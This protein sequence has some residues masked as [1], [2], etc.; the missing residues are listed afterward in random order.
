MKPALLLKLLASA[1]LAVCSC[2]DDICSEHSFNIDTTSNPDWM[3]SLPDDTALTALSIPGTHDTMTYDVIDTIYQCNNQDLEMQLEAGVRYFDIRG[4]L[5]SNSIQIYHSIVYTGY[6]L[7]YVLLTFFSFLEHHPGE[8][9]IMRLKNEASPI[10]STISFEEGWK[11]YLY[12]NTATAS[13]AAKYLYM[14]SDSVFSPIPDLGQLR[15]KIL[16]LQNFES[17]PANKYGIGWETGAM[18]LEDFWQMSNLASLDKKFTAITDNLEYAA[19]NASDGLLYLTHL[20]ASVGVL[21]I[22]AAAGLESWNVTGMNDRTGDWLAA[23][24]G[25]RTGVVIMDF[26]GGKLVN[27]ILSRNSV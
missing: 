14:P 9:I 23:R 15:G 25:Q 17:L 3:A 19:A 18:V 21:P 1:A 5:V 4:R 26:P 27:E 24:A 20:S 13:D 8:T 16:L 6:S 7:E 2:Y 11:Q 12:N 10:L 22:V